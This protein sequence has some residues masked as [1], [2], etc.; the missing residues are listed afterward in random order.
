[1][2]A[3]T[4]SFSAVPAKPNTKK[5]LFDELATK[6]NKHGESHPLVLQHMSELAAHCVG[7][8]DY[9]TAAQV[10]LGL[11]AHKKRD[12]GDSCTNSDCVILGTFQLFHSTADG[13]A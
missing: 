6:I 11:Y 8:E 10:Y 4:T 3:P 5:S 12:L 7:Q 2:R 13:Q 9:E 1:M